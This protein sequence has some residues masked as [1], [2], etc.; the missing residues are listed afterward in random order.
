LIIAWFTATSCGSGAGTR[1]RC[2]TRRQQGGA[3]ERLRIARMLNDVV[4]HS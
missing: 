4:A 1:S 2:R 3:E